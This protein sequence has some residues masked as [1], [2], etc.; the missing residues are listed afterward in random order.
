MANRPASGVD[1]GNSTTHISEHF[2][3][4]TPEPD[5]VTTGL[6]S[7]AQSRPSSETAVKTAACRG[8]LYAAK[9]IRN[10]DGPNLRISEANAV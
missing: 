9:Y 3:A 2:A 1:P 5:G 10:L 8:V 7:T 4:P 6:G